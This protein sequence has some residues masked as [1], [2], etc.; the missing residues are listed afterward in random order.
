MRCRPVPASRRSGQPKGAEA[1]HIEPGVGGVFLSPP[2]PAAHALLVL[3]PT[4]R[5]H[6]V[7]EAAQRRQPVRGPRL[8]Q[9]D[10]CDNEAEDAQAEAQ[11]PAP[12]HARGSACVDLCTRAG[13]GCGGGRRSRPQ[14]WLPSLCARRKWRTTTAEA[15]PYMRVTITTPRQSSSFHSVSSNVPKSSRR[16]AIAVGLLPLKWAANA[17]F[18]GITMGRQRAALRPRGAATHGGAMLCRAPWSLPAGVR[19]SYSY[20]CS[21]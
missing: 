14:G 3:A 13:R 2:P 5:P 19:R 20:S 7:L 6:C 1:S 10:E 9:E 16:S 8:D 17:G 18:I 12:V 21:V 4:T 15:A 11:V